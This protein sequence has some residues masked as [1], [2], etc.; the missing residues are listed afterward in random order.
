MPCLCV[1]NKTWVNL[2]QSQ[3]QEYLTKELLV[4]KNETGLAKNKLISRSDPRESSA[5]FGI[6]GVG[7]IF[8]MFG[9]WLLSDI[10]YLMQTIRERL[11]GKPNMILKRKNA[12]KEDYKQLKC[13]KLQTAADAK[14]V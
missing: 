1:K 10:T 3:I 4:P 11:P 6:M 14:N 8:A 7:L 2:T 9:V 13:E 5:I 12:E